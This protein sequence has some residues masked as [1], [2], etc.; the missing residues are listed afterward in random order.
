[1]AFQG[2]T[3]GQQMAAEGGDLLRLLQ[4][5]VPQVAAPGT[6]GLFEQSL[7]PDPYS[8]GSDAARRRDPLGPYAPMA[9]GGVAP[10]AAGKAIVDRLPGGGPNQYVP[11]VGR[12]P[13]MEAP[14]TYDPLSSI[15]APVVPA[16]YAGT[17]GAPGGAYNPQEGPDIPASAGPD[18]APP[19][20]G[21]A[22]PE[23]SAPNG[24]EALTQALAGLT[25]PP[26]KPPIGVATPPPPRAAPGGGGDLLAALMAMGGMG[27]GGPQ[28][29]P[30]GALVG[31]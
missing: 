27:R 9:V 13:D 4:M 7:E 29:P 19:I 25:A 10:G 28:I 21:S 17:G 14:P 3:G 16:P 24:M 18:A 26:T 12:P 11:G 30:L 8:P 5:L 15:R 23:P 20:G 31:R 6:G 1:M 2:F 22:S